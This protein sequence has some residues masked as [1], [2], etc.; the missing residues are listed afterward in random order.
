MA[1][2]VLS[3]CD[4]LGPRSRGATLAALTRVLVALCLAGCL[5]KPRPVTGVGSEP[6]DPKGRQWATVARSIEGK[7][8]VRALS[9]GGRITCRLSDADADGRPELEQ[10]FDETG[11]L[12]RERFDLDGDGRFDRT[13]HLVRGALERRELDTNGD[14][15]TD[16]RMKYA[17]GQLSRIEADEDADGRF[18]YYEDWSGGQL[19]RSGLL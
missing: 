6:C 12:V 13:D 1:I 11:A 4:E 8:T 2:Y 17:R 19:V 9:L 16:V 10:A 14:G 15:R 18:D 7:P 3:K 5:A